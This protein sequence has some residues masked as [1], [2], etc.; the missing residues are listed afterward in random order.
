MEPSVIRDLLRIKI[1]TFLQCKCGLEN[2]QIVD[3]THINLVYP[4]C[5]PQGEPNNF[6]TNVGL[7][8]LTFFNEPDYV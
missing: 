2:E 6:V 1:Q 8:F 4:D 5:R 7:Q 3:Q